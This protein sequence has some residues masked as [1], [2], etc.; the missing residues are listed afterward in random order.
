[1]KSNVVTHRQSGIQVFA[2]AL[3]HK[4]DARQQR[5]A[6]AAAGGIGAEHAHA[7]LL[8]GFHAGHQRQQRRFADA[9]RPDHADAGALRQAQRDIVERGFTAVGVA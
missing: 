1:M 8:D 4:G 6:L 9:V 3:R 5:F 2:Q 7:A